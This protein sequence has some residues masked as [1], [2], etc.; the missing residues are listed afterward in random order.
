MSDRDI[1][2][3]FHQACPTRP[4][5]SSG[6]ERGHGRG[7][8][9]GRG[10]RRIS[11]AAMQR[12]N[13]LRAVA[14]ETTAVLPDIL[15]DIKGL[16]PT[17]TSIHHARYLGTLEAKDCPGFTLPDDDLQAGMK[18]T[19]VRVCDQD[20][21]DAALELQ[22]DTKVASVIP[23]ADDGDIE[24][25]PVAVLNLA[26]ELH[27]GGGWLN[28]ALAQEEALCY[29]SS[30]SLALSPR[31]YPIP[32]LSLLYTPHCILIRT[33]MGPGSGHQLL[34]PSTTA[35]SLPVTSVI[36]VAAL[37]RPE[38]T[39]AGG[40]AS[41]ADVDTTKEKI[42]I[43]LRIAA[44]KQH[45]KIV[46]G[47]MGCGAFMNPPQEVANCFADVLRE[48]EFRGGWWEDVIFAVLDNVKGDQGGKDGSGNFGI[49]YRTLNG[50][51]A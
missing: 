10:R 26:S 15:A 51:I 41:V 1:R 39:A 24:L 32:C 46:L 43:V 14:A 22:P 25:K 29:R 44:M 3:F 19:R 42:R 27:P 17:A 23:R 35:E 30:L 13:E 36:S 7:R 18:G 40:F 48:N 20:T 34:Y 5:R 28:G 50:I 31:F 6:H 12:R 33:A 38:I 16:D 21:F 47:A 2:E 45:R 37:R 11:P 8:G 49:F 9:R 4:L